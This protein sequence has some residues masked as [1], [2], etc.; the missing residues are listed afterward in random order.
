MAKRYRD[1]SKFH[2]IEQ[3][4][5]FFGMAPGSQSEA[6]ILH[7]GRIGRWSE[8]AAEAIGN[9]HRCRQLIAPHHINHQSAIT[10]SFEPA[11]A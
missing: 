7:V 3:P 1:R 4:D 11:F 10:L 9:H 6:G 8:S 2:C 5:G